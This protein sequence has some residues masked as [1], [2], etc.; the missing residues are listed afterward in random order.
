MAEIRDIANKEASLKAACTTPDVCRV[1]KDVIPFDSFRDLSH[2]K[3][4]SPN[5]KAR[6]VPVLT[7]NSVISGTSGNAGKGISSSVAKG[8]GDVLI[9]SG[10]GNVKSNNLAQAYHLSEVKINCKGPVCNADGR[11]YTGQ[12]VAKKPAVEN[13]QPCNQPPKT[14]KELEA[15]KAQRDK[16]A[17]T[18]STEGIDQSARLKGWQD[19]AQT[20]LEQTYANN[21]AARQAFVNRQTPGWRQNTAAGLAAV[22]NVVDQAA[23]GLVGGVKDLG[24]GIGQ[25]LNMGVGAAVKHNPVSQGIQRAMTGGASLADLDAMILA[26]NIQLG[27]VCAG[28]VWQGAKDMG[29]AIAEPVMN[30]LNNGRPIGAAARIVTDVV[31]A[32]GTGG[33]GAAAKGGATVAGAAAR[34]GGR[35]AGEAAGELAG[36]GGRLA[37]ETAGGAGRAAEAVAPVAAR[38]EA[39]VVAEAAAEAPAVR[40]KAKVKSLRDR[41]LGDTPGKGDRTGREV[42]DRMRKEGTLRE[43]EITGKTEFQASDKQWYPLEKADMAHYPKDAV[44]WWNETG[45]QYGAKS[46]EVRAFMLDS[47]NYVLDHYSLNRSAGATLGQTVKYLPPLK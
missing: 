35:V 3:V 23:T 36:V 2:E 13:K 43:N 30:E 26:K 38:A 4:Y 24:L 27:N 16:L 25:L 1:G 6:G 20:Y 46:P 41:Y 28:S 34:T 29:H 45:R 15:L 42:Q 31:A 12:T 10:S 18:F 7:V 17:T 21:E 47:K 19:G 37:T 11:L 32:V 39:K 14:D 8:S 5:V 44:T 22:D 40:I 33:G 9:K